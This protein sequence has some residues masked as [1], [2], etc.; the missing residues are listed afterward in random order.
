MDSTTKGQVWEGEREGGGGHEYKYNSW[1]LQRSLRSSKKGAKMSVTVMG[2]SCFIVASFFRFIYFAILISSYPDSDNLACVEFGLKG[3]NARVDRRSVIVLHDVFYPV[4]LM[5]MSGIVLYW[6]ELSRSMAHSLAKMKA[7]KFLGPTLLW[8]LFGFSVICFLLFVAI[9][10]SIEDMSE[11]EFKD[12]G[13]SQLSVFIA[14][15]LIEA[16]AYYYFGM[17]VVEAGGGREK[18]RKID[19]ILRVCVGLFAF[20]AVLL[21]IILI[22]GVLESAA[23]AF[24]LYSLGLH[25]WE[26]CVVFFM[27]S[28]LMST[29]PKGKRASGTFGVG[30]LFTFSSFRNSITSATSSTKKML[31]RRSFRRSSSGRMFSF[32]GDSLKNMSSDPD[33][34]NNNNSTGLSSG[35]SGLGFNRG[36]APKEEEKVESL[37]SPST[38][39]P[40]RTSTHQEEKK[41]VRSLGTSDRNQ[42]RS[43][44]PDE[45]ELLQSTFDLDTGEYVSSKQKKQ[46]LSARRNEEEDDDDRYGGMDSEMEHVRDVELIQSSFDLDTEEATSSKQKRA[47]KQQQGGGGKKMMLT[48]IQ[49]FSSSEDE[50]DEEGGSSS[51]DEEGGNQDSKKSG[52]RGVHR[53]YSFKNPLR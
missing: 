32:R 2:S 25:I 8:V 40:D 26:L 10:S 31:S 48:G 17:K 18:M 19:K 37:S 6:F 44:A 12:A 22:P 36:P 47:Q 23:A 52:E 28:M 35:G 13:T 11:D 3:G 33:S 53:V 27:M 34:N 51:S 49:E 21:M 4:F 24:V 15:A 39:T 16:A 46:A 50:E 45:V 9:G 7:T 41:E 42:D 43:E 30:T 29:K 38:F 14:I 5:A 1:W 20:L